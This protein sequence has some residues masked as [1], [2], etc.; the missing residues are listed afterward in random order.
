[1]IKSIVIKNFESHANTEI[2]FHPGV[3]VIIGRTDSG[4]SA[5][6]RALYWAFF[7]KPYGDDYV[8]TGSKSTAVGVEFDNGL[9]SRIRESNFNGYLLGLKDPYKGFSHNIPEPVSNFINMSQINFQRQ[10]DSHFML[11]WPAGQRGSFINDT[12]NLE[13]MDIAVSNIKRKIS[14]ETRLIESTSQHIEHMEKELDEFEDLEEIEVLIENLER[15]QNRLNDLEEKYFELSEIIND[16]ENAQDSIEYHEEKI[17]AQRPVL[18]ACKV[19]DEYKALREE[20]YD[21]EDLIGTIN[22]TENNIERLSKEI[23]R[24][25]KEFNKL[26][27]EVCPLCGSEK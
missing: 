8:R 7:N 15:K 5:I 2:N 17:K 23:E 20:A 22:Q 13:S 21:L 25:T 11:S 19:L 14:E 6:M 24:S 27:P 3:N 12:V 9:V 16:I 26:M 1:M 18:G 10:A 4:K